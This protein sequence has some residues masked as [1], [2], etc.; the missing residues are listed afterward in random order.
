ME[1]FK[2]MGSIARREPLYRYLGRFDSLLP[3]GINEDIKVANG[4]GLCRPAV[5]QETCIWGRTA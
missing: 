5:L 1:C 2:H 4:G 3:P